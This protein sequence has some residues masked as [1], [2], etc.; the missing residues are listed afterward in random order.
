MNFIIGMIIGVVITILIGS[1]L[2]YKESIKPYKDL[3]DKEKLSFKER[4]KQYKNR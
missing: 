3:T 1:Y 2:A 4:L